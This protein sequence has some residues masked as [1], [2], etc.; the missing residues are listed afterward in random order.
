M[1]LVESLIEFFGI[2]LLQQAATFTDVISL[3][4]EIGVGVWLTLFICRCLFL[5]C[6]IGDRRFY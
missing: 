4:L 3:V 1:A 5:A 6:T 2:D